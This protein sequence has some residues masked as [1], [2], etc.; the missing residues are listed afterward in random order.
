[1]LQNL[2]IDGI[3]K[4][5]NF[6]RSGH[7]VQNWG[8]NNI[9][10]NDVVFCVP[11]TRSECVQGM[12]AVVGGC[13]RDCKGAMPHLSPDSPAPDNLSVF[14]WH[15]TPVQPPPQPA[16]RAYSLPDLLSGILYLSNSSDDQLST[17][18]FPSWFLVTLHCYVNLYLI[19]YLF[20]FCFLEEK[21]L[22]LTIGTSLPSYFIFRSHR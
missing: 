10:T 22:N 3:C 12:A 11:H 8:Y 18:I 19:F 21:A 9:N 1:M 14:S 6:P 16:T 4:M 13:V 7:I 2:K 15:Q 17:L 5:L 20:I